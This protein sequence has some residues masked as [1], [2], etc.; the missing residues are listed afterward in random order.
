MEMTAKTEKHDDRDR[1]AQ[2]APAVLAEWESRK[3]QGALSRQAVTA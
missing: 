3:K 1:F 2:A